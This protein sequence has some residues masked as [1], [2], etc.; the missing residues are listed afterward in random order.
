MIASIIALLGS[1]AFGSIIGGIFAILNR[2]ADVD[3]KNLELAHERARWDHDATMRDKDLAVA[4]AEAAGRKEVAVI[5]G[6]AAFETARM[7][8]I[9]QVASAEHIGA[10]EIKAAGKWGVLLVW[11]SVFNKLIRPVLTVLLAAAALWLN[12]LLIHHMT[13][14]WTDMTQGQ[15][16]EAGMQ[17]FAWVTAQASTAFAYWFVS[18]GSGK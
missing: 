16:F 5:E 9:G 11:A 8:A 10:D 1:S 3:V 12:W 18:R 7:G 15:R 13:D 17:A 4:Q 2:K 6:E 14:G